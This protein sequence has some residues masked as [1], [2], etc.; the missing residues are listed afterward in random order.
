MNISPNYI[1]IRL[2]RILSFISVGHISVHLLEAAFEIRSTSLAGLFNFFSMGRESNLPTYISALNLLFASFLCLVI[3][4]KECVERR[5]KARPWWG[6]FWGLLLM[7]FDEA[8]MIHEGIVGTLLVGVVGQGEGIFYYMWYIAY[9]PVVLIVICLYLP[10]LKSLPIYYSSRLI[11]SGLTFLSGAVGVEM[12]D[13]YFAFHGGFFIAG[14]NVQGVMVL[15]EEFL[16]MLGIIIL[17]YVLLK[18]LTGLRH[19]LEIRFTQDKI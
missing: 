19:S 8:A 2:L 1:L 15:I 11:L 9:I 12:M 5:S 17:I 3:A 14:R 16:E 7:S 18:Y 13:S 4:R 6:L 10:F